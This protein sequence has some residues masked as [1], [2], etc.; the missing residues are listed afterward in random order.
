[1]IQ[2]CWYLR[3]STD[4]WLLSKNSTTRLEGLK[5]LH[6]AGLLWNC[7]I[8]V[9]N[10]KSL[11]LYPGSNTTPSRPRLPHVLSKINTMASCL[12]RTRH[13]FISFFIFNPRHHAFPNAFRFHPRKSPS[14]ERWRTPDRIR[15]NRILW[16]KPSV[17]WY[18]FAKFCPHVS[19][20]PVQIFGVKTLIPNRGVLETA[21]SVSALLVHRSVCLGLPCKVI[22]QSI[23][24]L[25]PLSETA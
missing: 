19:L 17:E 8:P 15:L 22:L 21:W 10:T 7:L 4:R 23:V 2:G 13:Q 1:M 5:S 14:T 18:S 11:Y 3:R 25:S 9:T 24:S 16:E 6:G 20:F 12:S